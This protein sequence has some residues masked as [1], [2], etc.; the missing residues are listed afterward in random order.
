M[1]LAI[2]PVRKDARGREIQSE[3]VIEMWKLKSKGMNVAE[4]AAATVSV[5]RVSVNSRKQ[6]IHL[7]G[8]V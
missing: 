6:N 4:I 2:T 3:K 7:E 1:H 8:L 5:Q